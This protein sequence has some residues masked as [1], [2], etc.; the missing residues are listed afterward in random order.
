M[1]AERSADRDDDS[2]IQDGLSSHVHE[3]TAVSQDLSERRVASVRDALIDRAQ[4]LVTHF[5]GKKPTSRNRKGQIRW[6]TKGS[7]E[8]TLRGRFRGYYYDFEA[9]E[10]GDLFSLIMSRQGLSF[11]EAVEWAARWVGLPTDYEPTPEEIE[12]EKAREAARRAK[13]AADAVED[14]AEQAKKLAYVRQTWNE[15]RAIDGTLGEK[16]LCETRKI[17][18]LNFPTSIRW[19]VK[20]SAIVCAVTD[21]AGELVAIQLIAITSEGKKDPGRWQA[22]AKMSLGPVGKGV[23][24]FPGAPDSPICICEGIETGLTVWAATRHETWVLLGGMR[25]A[26]EVAPAGRRIIVCRDDD[27]ITS[28]AANS[29]KFALR[30]LRAKGLDAREAWPHAIHRGDKSDFND[31]AQERGLDAVRER[32]ALAAS[33]MAQALPIFYTRDEARLRVA[34]LIAEFF[35][36]ARNWLKSDPNAG[37]GYYFPPIHAIGLDVGGGKTEA[38][39]DEGI[40]LLVDLRSVGDKRVVVILVPEHRL[41]EDIDERVR[42]KLKAIAP[43]LGVCVWRGRAVKRPGFNEPMCQAHE[44]VSEAT[45]LLAD[46]GEEICCKKHC[47]F[48][49]GCQYRLQRGLMGV[50]LWIGAHNLLFSAAPTPIKESGVAAVIVDEGP[51]RAGLKEPVELPLDAI[52]YERM[53]L[54]KK[55]VDRFELMDA[56]HRLARALSGAPDGFLKRDAIGD[57]SHYN[58]DSA[59]AKRAKGLEW[60]RVIKKREIP[61]WRERDGNRTVRPMVEIWDA[62]NELVRENGPEVSGRLKIIRDERGARVLRVVGRSNVHDDWNA[63]TLLIDALHDPELIRPFWETVEDK[64]HVR[65]AAPFMRVRQAI[66]KSYSLAHLSPAAEGSEAAKRTRAN[67]RRNVRALILRLAREVGGRTLVV[68]NKSVVLAMEFPPHI[69]VAWFSAVAGRDRWKDVRLIVV[70]GRPQPRPSS[71]EWMAAALA[72]RAVPELGNDADGAESARE[73]AGRWYPKGDAFQ[74]KR[75]G[76]DLSSVLAS[77]DRHPH[78]LCESIRWRICEGEIIQAIGR[79]RGVNRDEATPLDVVVLNDVPLPLPVDQFLSPDTVTASPVDL[80]LAEGG[81]AFFDGSSAATA[82]PNLWTTPTAA[83]MGLYRARF[84]RGTQD[85][86]S[87]T[88]AYREYLIGK[89]YAD[90][91]LCPPIRF[92]RVGPTRHEE[93]AIYDPQLVTDPRAA[94][95]ALVGGLATFEI[96]GHARD[97]EAGPETRER[98]KGDVEAYLMALRTALDAKGRIVLVDSTGGQKSFGVDRE[99]VREAFKRRRPVDR[100]DSKAIDARKKAFERGEKKALKCGLIEL[101]EIGGRKF[102]WLAADQERDDAPQTAFE[103]DAPP[104]VV[105]IS[106]AIILDFPMPPDCE[107]GP[108]VEA[109]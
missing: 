21:M 42:Q 32:I 2:P 34:R 6:G 11:A 75:D 17:H 35:Q 101:I 3:R 51:F 37:W 79:G 62:V 47:T 98:M 100:G 43:N 27:K 107:A 52:G 56:R 95:E 24:R 45:R 105:T 25:R 57:V 29:V 65:I 108:V 63:P 16:Y 26:A 104:I 99:E 76:E 88:N 7:F 80:M 94:I 5:L 66:H 60:T 72:G 4:E 87:V 61:N 90:P 9:G 82:Y 28:P 73:P 44:T 89:C 77:A 106:N 12:R 33:D 97:A 96:V 103:V 22:G 40:R 86:N 70:L 50:D 38:A 92:R 46:I 48:F 8:L 14:A 109:A 41:A 10:G 71:V 64:G 30:D 39:I 69:E 31:V 13:E 83:R 19:S 59:L 74:I 53:P 1:S 55:E 58:I 102:V 91:P 18:L 49:E 20:R 23:V 85:P 15:A 78:E 36:T 68:G 81:V 93:M 67:N 84:G 54:P